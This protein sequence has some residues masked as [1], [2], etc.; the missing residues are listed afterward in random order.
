VEAE[1]PEALALAHRAVL[2]I[3]VRSTSIRALA[4]FITFTQ[5]LG[6]DEK[7]TFLHFYFSVVRDGRDISKS[8]HN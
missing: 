8:I 1:E 6:I 5:E 4:R 7:I 2:Q 3:T